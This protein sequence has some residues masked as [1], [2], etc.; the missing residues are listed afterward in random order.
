MMATSRRAA[1]WIS[2]SCAPCCGAKTET[3]KSSRSRGSH[4]SSRRMT[5]SIDT[6]RQHA[7]KLREAADLVA[8]GTQLDMEEALR[9]AARWLEVAS[10]EIGLLAP[11]AEPRGVKVVTTHTLQRV[12]GKPCRAD[13]LE[14]A[15][16]DDIRPGAGDVLRV[17]DEGNERAVYSVIDVQARK[18]LSSY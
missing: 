4:E 13:Q 15:I 2:T 1:W 3:P 7:Q 12:S 18:H 5:M 10:D 11:P 9:D 6:Y 17:F 16:L 14:K 8:E